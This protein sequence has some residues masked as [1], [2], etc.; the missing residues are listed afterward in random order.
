[1]VSKQTG[2]IKGIDGEMQRTEKRDVLCG[3]DFAF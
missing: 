3:G 2:Q 1:M